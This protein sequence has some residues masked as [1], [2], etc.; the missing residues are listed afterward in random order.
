[1]NLLPAALSVAGLKIRYGKREVLRGLDLEVTKGE[2]FGLLGPNGA[3]KTTLIRTICGRLK[4]IAG[5]VSIV[6]Q[7]VSR[8]SLRRIGLVPQD[9]ALYPHLTARENLEVFGQLSGLTRPQALSAMEWASEAANIRERLDERIDILSGGW[10]RR[11]NIAAAILHRP[12]LLILDE[13]TVGVDVDARNG[14]HDVIQQLSQAGMGVLLATHDLDQAE[15]LCARVG[16]LRGGVI[17]PQGNPRALIDE[18]FRGQRE[19]I[20]EL[21]QNPTPAQ[22]RALD[23]SGFSPSNGSLSWSRIGQEADRSAAALAEAFER[24]GLSTREIRFREPGLDSLFI[25]LSR[26]SASAPEETAA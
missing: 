8:Q 24:A 18:T 23:K 13:P 12:D 14:L 15:L 9:I 16:F 17:A 5:Q 10:K 11:V 4:P 3:G 25:H 20:I 22:A 19:I 21:R 6:G 1:M 26:E 2:I 7:P